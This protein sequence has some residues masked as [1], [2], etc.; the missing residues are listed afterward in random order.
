MG[1]MDK[2]KNKAPATAEVN[3][4]PAPAPAP[5]A[6]PAPVPV[7]PPKAKVTPPPVPKVVEVEAEVVVVTDV[8]ETPGETFALS[9]FGG[10]DDGSG[11]VLNALI[12]QQQASRTF[13]PGGAFPF[14]SQTKGNA[15][16]GLCADPK[17]TEDILELLPQGKGA[18]TAVFI[19]HR[20]VGAGWPEGLNGEASPQDKAK[21]KPV[22]KVVAASNDATL[23]ALVR[24]AGEVYQFTKGTLKGKFDGIGHF[25]SGVELLFF[26]KGVVF[27]VA[28][29]QHYSSLEKTLASLAAAFPNGRYG[30]F[31]CK[32]TPFSEPQPGA[33]PWTAHSLKFAVAIDEKGAETFNEFKA[34]AAEVGQDAEFQAAF[35]AWKASECDD[36]AVAR[37]TQIGSMGR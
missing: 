33:V 14:I 3:T 29:P 31:P 34:F 35:A 13:S 2:Y 27:V 24:K 15:G 36:D 37:L 32:V 10:A 21:T 8:P 16:G 5:K 30:A 19:G 12:S 6:A 28:V 25:R 18:F 11:D 20:L 1:F 7:T 22:F 17:I 23:C 9:V 26:R 4:T